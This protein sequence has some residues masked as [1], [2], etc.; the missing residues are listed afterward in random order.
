MNLKVRKTDRAE[1]LLR[2]VAGGL[3]SK[4]QFLTLVEKSFA[5][6]PKKSLLELPLKDFQEFVNEQEK[7]GIFGLLF[8]L[9]KLE[10]SKKP[11][12][13]VLKMDVNKFLSWFKYIEIATKRINEHFEAIPRVPMS[14]LVENASKPI[15]DFGIYAIVDRLAVRQG[16]TDE[17]AE[18]MP[19]IVA[20]TKLKIDA[21]RALIEYR[22]NEASMRDANRKKS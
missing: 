21:E 18:Q 4:E 2:Y 1:L 3:I 9:K 12:K 19:L 17:Q 7:G 11:H 13:E 15:F 16:I 14:L 20:I 6:E 10:N 22:V 5:Y 8:L